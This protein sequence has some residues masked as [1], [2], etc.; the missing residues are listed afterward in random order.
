MSISSNSSRGGG[1]LPY[2]SSNYPMPNGTGVMGNGMT[3]ASSSS[4]ITAQANG[5]N[6]A[7]RPRRPDSEEIKRVGRM[8]YQE[9]FQ[10]LRTHLAKGE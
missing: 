7:R 5:S 8:H 6:P 3:Q 4:T 2:Q 1:G 10:F 9:L